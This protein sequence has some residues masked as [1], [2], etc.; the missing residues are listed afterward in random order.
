MLNVLSPPLQ[1]E[2]LSLSG[3]CIDIYVHVIVTVSFIVVSWWWNYKTVF[4]SFCHRCFSVDKPKTAYF[5][6]QT[7][8]SFYERLLFLDI[9]V[10]AKY[11]HMHLIFVDSRPILCSATGNLM[12]YFQS[13]VVFEDIIYVD[14]VLK[15]P[16]VSYFY[17]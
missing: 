9:F 7:E 14:Y 16:P 1:A 12:E 8:E 3:M 11:Q 5:T 2:Y 10:I 6:Y 15:V 4:P 13:S 17:I